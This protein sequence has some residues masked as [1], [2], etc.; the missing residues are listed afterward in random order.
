MKRFPA[1]LIPLLGL[2]ILAAALLWPGRGGGYHANP[3]DPPLPMAEFTLGAGDEVFRSPE[4]HGAHTVLFFGFTHCPDVCPLTL[5][6]LAAAR[7]EMGRAGR[8]VQVLFVSVDPD[9]DDMARADA[10]A[11]SFDPSFR[12]VAGSEEQTRALARDY[13][14]HFRRVDAADHGDHGNHGVDHTASALVLNSSGELVML[15]PYGQS[16]EE[17]AS[18]LRR[19]VRR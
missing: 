5:Q 8:R 3:V 9:R 4:M 19:L 15:F 7:Q 13:G 12:G 1:V 17:M 18:D 16:A 2:A 14:V 10:Y 11:K 6:R